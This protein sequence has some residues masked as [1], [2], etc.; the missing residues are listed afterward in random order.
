MNDIKY[1]NKD[2]KV[3]LIAMDLVLVLIGIF[4]YKLILFDCWAKC[5]SKFKSFLKSFINEYG[6]TVKQQTDK[7]PPYQ[8]DYV[9]TSFIIQGQCTLYIL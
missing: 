2:T 5:N 8:G 3:S 9:N 6:P 7:N 4:N 1:R